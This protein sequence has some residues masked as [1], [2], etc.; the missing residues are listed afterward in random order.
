MVRKKRDT[1]IIKLDKLGKQD[2]IYYVRNK[3]EEAY[4]EGYALGKSLM[5]SP[6]SKESEDVTNNKTIQKVV[7]ILEGQREML[8]TTGN[9]SGAKIM[10]VA[11]NS[12]YKEMIVSPDSTIRSYSCEEECHG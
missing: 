5:D 6:S 7:N 10:E 9:E 12:V 3:C 2:L 8:L 1:G 4:H 11:I